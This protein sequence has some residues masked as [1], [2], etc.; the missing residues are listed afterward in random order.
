MVSQLFS[1]LKKVL[2][3]ILTVI[4]NS[5]MSFIGCIGH[6]MS[7]SGQQQILELVCAPNTDVL[8]LT[9]KAIARA[10]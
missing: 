4:K 3:N 1:T 9:G 10:V 8:I 5:E 6:L 2:Y 7:A